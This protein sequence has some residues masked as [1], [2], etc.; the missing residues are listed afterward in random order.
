[1]DHGGTWILVPKMELSVVSASGT[2]SCS[3][4]SRWSIIIA[5]L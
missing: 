5:L 4:L 1:M 2:C 3:S